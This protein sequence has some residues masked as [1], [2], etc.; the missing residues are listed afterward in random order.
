M[1]SFLF[2]SSTSFL[3]AVLLFMSGSA[4]SVAIAHDLEHASHHTAG[5]HSTGICAWMCATGAVANHAEVYL[6]YNPFLVWL[7]PDPHEDPLHLLS[8]GRSNPRAPPL[9]AS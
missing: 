4:M 6:I 8:V 9:S 5:S 1:K 7:A 2:R 3:L